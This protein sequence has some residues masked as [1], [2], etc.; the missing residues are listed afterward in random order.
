MIKL[1]IKSELPSAVRWTNEMTRQL[2]Y[3]AANALNAAVQGSKFIAGSKQKSSLN[4][5]AGSSR[6]Y[7]DRP[8]KPF[9]S[10]YDVGLRVSIILSSLL[11]LIY[12]I[13][14]SILTDTVSHILIY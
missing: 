9:D 14:P 4:A 8:K 10:N 6:R 3:S 13:Y 1:D 2:P 5:L 12:F 7:F 11:V